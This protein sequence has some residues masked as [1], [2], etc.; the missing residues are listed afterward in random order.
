MIRVPRKNTQLVAG[1]I[2]ALSL[3]LTVQT[4]RADDA[5]TAPSGVLLRGPANTQIPAS[6][7]QKAAAT[8]PV[9][10]AGSATQTSGSPPLSGAGPTAPAVTGKDSPVDLDRRTA[11][12]A[13]N[14]KDMSRGRFFEREQHPLNT[15]SKS[16]A[17]PNAMQ[18]GSGASTP[19][20]VSPQAP[21]GA[22]AGKPA[23]AATNAQAAASERLTNPA[24]A[25]SA[26]SGEQSKQATDKRLETIELKRPELT[27]LISVNERLSPL[28][29][30]ASGNIPVSFH[31][32]LTAAVQ[33]N[34]DIA[35][36]R[37]QTEIQKWTYLSA[38]SKFLPDVNMGYQKQYVKGL[39]F[40]PL[41]TSSSTL[42]SSSGALATQAATSNKFAKISTP[43]TV[44]NAGFTYHAYQGGKVAFS[45]LENH[46]RL[47]AARAAQHA[48]LSDTL[49]TVAKDYYSLLLNE[50]FLQIQIKAVETSEEQVR[51]NSDLE[52]SGLATNL[53]VLQ[54]RT[55]LSRDRVNLIDQ[56][57]A[58]RVAAIKLADTLNMNMAQDLAPAEHELRKVRLVDEDMGI[59]KMLELAI[60]NRPELKQYEELRRA[61]KKAIVVAAAP[62]QPKVNIGGNIYGIGPALNNIEALYQLSFAINFSFGGLGMT[63]YSNIQTAKWKARQA[64]VLANKE[65]NTVIDQARTAFIDSLTTE[66]KIDETV[67]EVISAEEELRLAK[68]RFENGLGTNLDIITAQRDR[69]T[70]YL[71][72]AQAIANYNIAE[73][74]L[75]HDLGVISVDGLTSGR[76]IASNLVPK[77]Y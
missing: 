67:N 38:M 24:P 72:R 3:I 33:H 16:V 59:G 30:D 14:K 4:V 43:F 62:L 17:S 29:I 36:Y 65:F 22:G 63:D 5:Q 50:A 2:S 8:A 71:E 74:Q 51:V 39:F 32:V 69:T 1:V 27:A 42:A 61:A 13:E 34:L 31:S 64:L 60:D 47:R 23:P 35:D 52:R 41:T 56:Q 6:Q 21:S 66:R 53:D 19:L 9:V 77:T 10:P 58:R 46:N 44:A 48:T 28:A 76:P 11:G 55:Q 45:A 49:L 20:S 18:S 54:S 12:S 7:S 15:Y 57:R 70:A 68:I 25:S 37:T 73:V 26:T 40:F 75:M